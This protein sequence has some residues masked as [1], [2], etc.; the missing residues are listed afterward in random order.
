MEKIKALFIKHKELILYVFF[1]GLTTLVNWGSF[2]VMVELL[3]VDYLVATMIAWVLSVLFAYVTN[4]KWVFESKN[5]GFKPVLLEMLAFFAARLLS[6]GMDMLFMYVGVGKLGINEHV[7]KLVSN[8]FVIIVNYFLSK[9][10]IFRKHKTKT[11]ET[12]DEEVQ[13]TQEA[14]VNATRQVDEKIGSRVGEFDES[15]EK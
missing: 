15:S 1:G 4:R 14:V 3:K 12:I 11:A 9:L 8:V 2:W 5:V 10:I 7:M 6:G 13:E